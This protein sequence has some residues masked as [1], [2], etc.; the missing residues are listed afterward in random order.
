[1]LLVFSMVGVFFINSNLVPEASVLPISAR[2]TQIPNSS[3]R[4]T[5]KPTKL[6][7]QKVSS[8]PT[9]VPPELTSPAAVGVTAQTG[10]NLSVFQQ[11]DFHSSVIYTLATG[12]GV[13]WLDERKNFSIDPAWNWYH[14]QYTDSAQADT[15][16]LAT[17]H[18]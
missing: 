5:E 6:A 10:Q 12:S 13:L 11:P 17:L 3:P 1:M 7:K 8:S 16:M 2:H 9:I 14:I 15:K 18:Y 4:P